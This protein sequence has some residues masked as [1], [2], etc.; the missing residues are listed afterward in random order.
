MISARGLETLINFRPCAA[1]EGRFGPRETPSRMRQGAVAPHPEHFSF[2][3]PPRGNPFRTV[4]LLAN[5]HRDL[6]NA[7]AR[8]TPMTA[9]TA[10]SEETEAL[11]SHAERTQCA[12]TA[13]THIQN[14]FERCGNPFCDKQREIKPRGKHGRYCSAPCRMDGYALKRAKALLNRVG[15]IRFHEL[16]DGL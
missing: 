3:R 5:D 11:L 16:L 8:P 14:G 6:S 1:L 2:S 10:T 12:R 15:I 13:L 9:L 4:R 7:T